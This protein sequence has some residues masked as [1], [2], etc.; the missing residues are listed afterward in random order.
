MPKAGA[1]IFR[2]LSKRYGI[3]INK[4]TGAIFFAIVAPINMVLILLSI[5][6]FSKDSVS[7]VLVSSF[8]FC[9]MWSL[10]L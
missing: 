5:I 10:P 9:F 8:D 4:L 7:V 3:I 2:L 1:L 6:L